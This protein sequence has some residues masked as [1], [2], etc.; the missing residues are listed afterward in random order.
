M[1]VGI[2]LILMKKVKRMREYL[3]RGKQVDRWEKGKWAEGHLKVFEGNAFIYVNLDNPYAIHWTQVDPETV[4][5]YTGLKDDNGTRVYEGDVIERRS[6]RRNYR[7]VV[8]A[9]EWNCGCCSDV[10]GFST[11]KGDVQLGDNFVVIGNI[12]D[13][14]ELLKEGG[15]E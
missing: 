4:G 3:F 1:I 15:E 11:Y 6:S 10:Y 13:N 9:E 5:Q 12:H 7:D 14:K 2:S 8:V